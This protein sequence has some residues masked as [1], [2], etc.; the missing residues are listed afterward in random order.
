ME[1][2]YNFLKLLY[3]D[4]YHLFLVQKRDFLEQKLIEDLC[5]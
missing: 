4:L 1:R 3:L 5:Y 2:Y